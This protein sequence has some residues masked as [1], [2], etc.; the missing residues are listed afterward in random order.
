MAMFRFIIGLFFL[1]LLSC[2]GTDQRLANI[3]QERRTLFLG[4][5]GNVTFEPDLQIELTEA[6]RNHIHLRR[7]YI[8]V[9]DIE[10]AR[11]ILYGEV[12][13]YRR[14]GFLFDNEMNPTRYDLNIVSKIRLIERETGQMVVTFDEDARTQYS[15]KEGMA[16]DEVVARQRLYGKL[17]R[18][19]YDRISMAFPL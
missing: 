13:L 2:V 1:A 5:F 8:L 15:T 7:G 19:I 12:I 11:F 6:L 3:P 18:K 10:K 14:E 16:E 4:N 17:C 9:D